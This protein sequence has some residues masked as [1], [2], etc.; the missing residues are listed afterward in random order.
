VSTLLTEETWLDQGKDGE[1][2]LHGRSNKPGGTYTLLLLMIA[3]GKTKNQMGGC[4]AERRIT[5]IRDARME[6]KS[7]K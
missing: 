5:D 2:N 1:T 7:G 4:C 3:S 6:E